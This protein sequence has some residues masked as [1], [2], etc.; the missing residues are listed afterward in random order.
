M[1]L[2]RY[3]LDRRGG[4]SG[5]YE[6]VNS[7]KCSE[8]NPEHAVWAA[9]WTTVPMHSH[10]CTW[11][12]TACHH[13]A[14]LWVHDGEVCVD[15]SD[16]WAQTDAAPLSQSQGFTVLNFS[17]V[18]ELP[19]EE[20][21]ENGMAVVPCYYI[22]PLGSTVVFP[23]LL[24]STICIILNSF[25]SSYLF[26][27][28]RRACFMSWSY[29]V[30]ILSSCVLWHD[31]ETFSP[32]AQ[33]MFKDS[34]HSGSRPREKKKKIGTWQSMWMGVRLFFS[35]IHLSLSMFP[36]LF[37]TTRNRS[38]DVSFIGITNTFSLDLH[39]NCNL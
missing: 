2:R 11:C 27:G 18:L 29:M 37:S 14:S 33:L 39:Q 15:G 20:L 36:L 32:L 38:L 8:S 30:Y 26:R 5:S 3:I 12:V 21:E 28:R 13:S 31:S 10:N 1:G 25:C 22:L 23:Y 19:C 6:G 7:R 9:E 17:A 34:Q 4:S 24:C 16:S 35:S